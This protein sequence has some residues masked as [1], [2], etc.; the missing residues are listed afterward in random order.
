MSYI[1]IPDEV[2]EDHT[3]PD[4]AMRLYGFANRLHMMK[5]LGCH[6]QNEYFVKKLFKNKDGSPLTE[7]QIK[8]HIRQVQRL[9]AL[10][11]ERGH[12]ATIYKRDTS[13]KI[14]SRKIVPKR[15]HKKEEKDA[16]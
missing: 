8:Q 15:V 12:I 4:K 6:A 10:L 2:Y 7:K 5:R 3:L 13:M 11:R 16:V 9:I 1:I 14:T